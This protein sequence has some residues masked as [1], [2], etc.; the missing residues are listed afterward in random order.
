MAPQFLWSCV[1]NTAMSPE[2][3]SEAFLMTAVDFFV[4][5]F[6]DFSRWLFR[7]DLCPRYFTDFLM[8]LWSQFWCSFI[9]CLIPYFSN[10]DHS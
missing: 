1:A 9:I 6:A 2:K 3:Y 8:H 4:E 10:L 7:K 5:K